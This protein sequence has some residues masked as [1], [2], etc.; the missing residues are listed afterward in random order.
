MEKQSA[1]SVVIVP[2]ATSTCNSWRFPDGMVI[3]GFWAASQKAK[4][5]GL[6]LQE[7]QKGRF[8]QWD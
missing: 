1:S 3:A 5:M 6:Q 7:R 2:F 4:S 8:S